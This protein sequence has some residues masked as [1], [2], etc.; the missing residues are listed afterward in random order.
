MEPAEVLVTLAEL[1]IGGR[2]LVR[3]RT[4]WRFAAVSRRDEML[5][6]LTVASAKG[7]TYRL[8]RPV[9]AQMRYD[10]S[11][12][13]IVCESPDTWKTNLLIIDQRW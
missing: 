11:I 7:R 9:D 2:V 4:D 13:Y 3:S 10:G 6:T 1:P 5:V 8:K 12:P